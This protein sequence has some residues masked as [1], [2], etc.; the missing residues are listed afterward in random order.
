MRLKTTITVVLALGFSAAGVAYAHTTSLGFVP[1]T[2]AGEVTFWTGS[3]NH[4]GTP[5]NEG[6]GTLAGVTVAFG[7]VSNP[8]NLGPVNVKP[9]GLVDGTNNFFWDSAF[10]FPVS[11]DPNLFGGVVWWQGVT[12]AGLV[13]GTYSFTCGSQCGV[14]AQW[15]S[16]STA[17]GQG[18]AVQVTLQAGDIGGGEVPEPAGLAVLGLALAGLAAARAHKSR[19]K[20]Y[21]KS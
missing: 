4:G 5:V 7:P 10:N 8:F 16:L 21:K 20:S 11:T 15:D 2:N 1:G 18:G 12:F 14:T 9:A 13:P 6:I 3:Y 17:G 19:K